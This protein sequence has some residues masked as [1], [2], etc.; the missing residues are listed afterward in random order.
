MYIFL[1]CPT[2]VQE[3]SYPSHEKMPTDSSVEVEGTADT[4]AT[5][6]VSK[7]RS[8]KVLEHSPDDEVEGEMVYLQSRLVDNAVVLK[9]RY[10]KSNFSHVLQYLSIK[11][12]K[13]FLP[14][15]LLLFQA[16]HF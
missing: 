9:H 13:I 8:L 12:A 15:P 14:F 6:Q 10:G 11:N 3:S 2:L 4:T 1:F 16:S 5:G 7:A